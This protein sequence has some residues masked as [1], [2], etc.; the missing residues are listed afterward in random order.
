[1]G[2]RLIAEKLESLRSCVRRIEAKC[3]GSSQLLRDTAASLDAT[4]AV[5][6]P[7]FVCNEESRFLVEE[8]VRAIDKEPVAIWRSSP[9]SICSM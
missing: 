9:H 2:R 7:V 8:Q 6:N 5:G 1:M 3:P 4:N